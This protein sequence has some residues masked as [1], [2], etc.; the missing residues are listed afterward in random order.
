MRSIDIQLEEFLTNCQIKHLSIKTIKSYNQSILLM[1][2]YLEHKYKITDATAVKAIHINSYIGYLQE[3]GKYTVKIDVEQTQPNYPERRSDYKRQITKTTINNYIRN[4]R[5]FFNYLV[6]FDYIDKSPMRKIR[7]LKNERKP[8]E[9]ITDTQF[10]SLLRYMDISL[11]H[12]YRDKV[13]NS[14]EKKYELELQLL[15]SSSIGE[16]EELEAQ[17]RIADQETKKITKAYK[18]YKGSIG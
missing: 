13:C 12:E 2:D 14:I 9:Y 15:L 1:A 6:D 4:M 17:L 3:R 11:Y 10:E 8:L 5:V 7:Q 18:A 16:R